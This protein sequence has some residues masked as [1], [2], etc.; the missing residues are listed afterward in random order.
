VVTMGSTKPGNKE[1]MGSDVA[2]ATS[3]FKSLRVAGRLDPSRENVADR[4][5][6]KHGCVAVHVD[7]VSIN[8]VSLMTQGRNHG[9][10]YSPDQG[11]IKTEH[12]SLGRLQ[13][14]YS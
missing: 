13:L 6:R 10:V 5:Y 3:F 14:G 4:V 11:T 8:I 1:D 12:R 7:H 9:L 2:I